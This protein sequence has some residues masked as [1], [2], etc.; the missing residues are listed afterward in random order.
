MLPGSLSRSLVQVGSP[1]SSSNDHGVVIMD[2]IVILDDDE[3][4]EHLQMS[5]TEPSSSSSL[6][7]TRR[8]T[9]NSQLPAPTHITQSPFAS[10]KKSSFVLQKEIETL[11]AEFVK[12]CQQQTTDCPEVLTFLEAKH[13]KATPEFL[14]SVEFRNTLGRCLTKAQENKTK[15]FVYIN[16]L[17]T[18]LKQH[19]T[20]RR[21]STLAP[22]AEEGAKRPMKE[23]EANAIEAPST[24]AQPDEDGV[25]GEEEKKVKKASRRQIA[26]LENLLKVYDEEIHRLQKK[27]LSLDELGE[28]D[29]SYI[30]EHKLKRKMMKIYDKLCELKGCSTLTGRVIEQRIVF[31]GSRHPV[32]N[33]KI[34]HFINR[35][36]LKE[37]PPDFRDIMQLVQRTNQRHNLLLTPNQVRQTAQEAF[38]ETGNLLQERRHLDLVYNFG[39]RLTDSYSQTSDP[40]IADLSLRQTLQKNRQ[41]AISGLDEVITKYAKQQD[42]IEEEE[43]KKRQKALEKKKQEENK[44]VDTSN[45]AEEPNAEKG[46][47]EDG[48]DGEEDEED[49]VSSD[50]DIEEEIEA[51]K[52]QEGPDVEGDDDDDDDKDDETNVS[53]SQIEENGDLTSVKSSNQDEDDK[54]EDEEREGEPEDMYMTRNTIVVEAMIHK[55]PQNTSISDSPSQSENDSNSCVSSHPTVSSHTEPITTNLDS[56]PPSPVV[57][58]TYQDTSVPSPCDEENNKS[59]RLCRK[60]KGRITSSEMTDKKRHKHS[61][62]DSVG[63]SVASSPLQADSTSEDPALQIVSSSQSTPPPKK[64]KVNKSTQYE[65]EVI[66][67]SDSD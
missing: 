5:S 46:S 55:A 16:E 45:T 64:N 54:E 43:R 48:N 11:F 52:A 13:K 24:S 1:A 25:T 60:R 44:N 14:S 63:V 39:S 32:I 2:S 4:D 67:L 9:L 53:D 40:A 51:S 38:Q 61:S 18:V 65:P 3:E 58:S 35:P 36:D 29:S 33:K 56:L 15:T 22:A 12:Y 28:E 7:T 21:L 41:V 47:D 34:E 66:I 37:N 49:D 42:D 6:P 59:Q 31:K 62:S 17:C 30:Q 19:S 8:I 20:K 10:A 23:E 26:Y 57:V 50:P 27:E